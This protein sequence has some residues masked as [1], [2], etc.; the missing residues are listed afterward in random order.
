M[1]LFNIEFTGKE[2]AVGIW[3][4][5]ETEEE[6]A[7]DAFE[8]CPEEL[9]S[10]PK[11]LEWLA[12]RVLTKTLLEKINL[13]YSGIIK[14][15]FGK[16]FLKELP[17][18]MSLTHSFPYVAAQIDMSSIVGIDLEQPKQKLLA[19]GSRVLSPTE[20][21]NAGNDLTK[22]C[23]YWCAKE[24]LYKIYGKRSLHF[25]TQLNIEPFVL[26]SSG[27]LNGLISANEQQLPVT[28][29]YRIDTNFVF[30]Y[31]QTS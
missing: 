25:S 1:P 16:P 24:A 8:Q 12:G 13:T 23:V 14:D 22:H 7:F 30:V 6:L 2:S 27:I 4:I 11:R 15:E 10:P 3:H 31:T 20:L 28:L 9:L 29:L 5:Q 26:Q 19:I 18:S 21:N 17:H